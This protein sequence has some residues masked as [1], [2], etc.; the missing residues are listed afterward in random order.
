MKR[1]APLALLLSGLS[2]T[3]ALAADVPLWELGAGVGVLSLPA[4]RGA[5]DTR[6]YVLPVPY[7]TYHGDFLRADRHGIRGVL[8][9]SDRIDLGISLA[10]SPPVGSDGTSARAGMPD[11]KATGEIGPQLD[12]TLWRSDS[13]ARKLTLIL[14]LRAAFTLTGP[15]RDKGWVFSPALN[16]DVADVAG[17]PGWKLGLRSG[18]IF[19]T[20]RQHAY[21]YEVAPAQATA[22]RPAY[23]ASGG[24][25]GSQFLAALSK[26]F[27]A[28]W[29]GGYVRYD[30]LQGAAFDDSPLVARNHYLAGGVA[31]A[32][33][34]G[35]SSQRVSVDD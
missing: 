24:Y 15:P 8:F 34:F 31:V 16:L 13:R 17:L 9:D 3:P 27:P 20:Q 19:A 22:T 12:L 4:W 14:P 5:A 11:L 35:E 26:R 7:F 2:A 28:Y 10:G 30:N 23:A 6:G 33:I 25:S 18:P 21:F 32:W 1:A 29:V